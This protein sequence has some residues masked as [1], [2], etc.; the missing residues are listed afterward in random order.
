MLVGGRVG[1]SRIV[2][3]CR[4]SLDDDGVSFFLFRSLERVNE[5]DVF[6]LGM[7]EVRLLLMSPQNLQ[8]LCPRYLVWV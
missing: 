8:R 7:Q 2:V 6:I 3:T 4:C 1:D 5:E